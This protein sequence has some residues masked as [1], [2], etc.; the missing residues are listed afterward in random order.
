MAKGR[1]KR[2]E[3]ASRHGAQNSEP[4][5]REGKNRGGGDTHLPKVD[6]LGPVQVEEGVEHLK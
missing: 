2:G 3:E 4:R 5:K 6:A 1:R